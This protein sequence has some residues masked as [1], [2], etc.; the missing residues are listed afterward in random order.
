MDPP[1]VRKPWLAAALSL[2]C[3]GLGHLYCGRLATALAL[4]L[5]SML[6]APA[7][8]VAAL[9]PPSD[10]LLWTLGT[11]TLASALLTV[12][13]AVHAA[14]LARREGAAFAPRD[15]QRAGV[16]A[17]FV[18]AAVLAPAASVV[19]IRGYVFAAYRIASG[20]M[21]PSLAQGD[22]V[23]VNRLRF[24]TRAVE[25][26]EI[27]VYHPEGERHAYVKRVVGLPGDRVEVRDGQ[28]LVDGAPLA[29]GEGQDDTVRE[30][31][32]ERTWR[33][34]PGAGAPD[35]PE[36]VVP[37]GSVYVLGDARDASLDSR[38]QGPVPRSRLVGPAEYVVEEDAAHVGAMPRDR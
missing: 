15:F 37:A 9:L 18:A 11:A 28:V 2:F 12:V 19:A 1:P 22:R 32:G 17:V 6:Y 14:R 25:R 20:S 5:L 29:A 16:Y 31:S 27:V 8:L 10:A 23:L 34:R 33:V 26:G 13:A 36:T 24:A 7:A 3:P 21:E 30:Q 35:V 4:L 38:T